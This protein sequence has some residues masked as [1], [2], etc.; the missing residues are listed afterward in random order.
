MVPPIPLGPFELQH[1]IGRG[2]MGDVWQGRHVAQDLPVAIKV[3][4]PVQ[5]GLEAFR[6]EVRA[7]AALDHPGVVA[8]HDMGLL[9]GAVAEASAGRLEAGSPYLVMELCHG[10]TLTPWCGRLAWPA[11]RAVL[12]SL[13]D[14]LAHAHARGVIHRDIKPA[15]VL[16]GSW[17][18][19][20]PGPKLVDFGV[21]WSLRESGALRTAGTRAY[22]APE[23]LHAAEL[24]PWTDLFALGRLALA[25][26]GGA[27]DATAPL[28]EDTP[29][30]LMPW[31]AR[32]LQ[33]DP[34]D[35]YA[36][37]ADAAEAL[38]GLDGA[39]TQN[40]ILEELEPLVAGPTPAADEEQTIDGLLDGATLPIPLADPTIDGLLDGSTLPM[41]LSALFTDR[42]GL[43]AP[44]PPLPDVTP[45][46]RV[47]ATPPGSWRRSEPTP[48]HPPL[49]GTGL[50]LHG[51]RTLPLIGRE[52]LRDR[53]W[54]ALLDVLYTRQARVLL[55]HG[56]AGSGRGR[57]AW[58]LGERATELGAARVLALPPTG[59]GKVALAS[60]LRRF[61]RCERLSPE[62]RVARLRAEPA[63]A[64]PGAL[65]EAIA[66]LSPNPA[67]DTRL[68]G[69]S[70]ARFR[71]PHE[72]V[73]AA[74]S[75]LERLC[76]ER[77]L[78]V[79]VPRVARSPLATRLLTRLAGSDTPLLAVATARDDDLAEPAPS[80]SALLGAPRVAWIPVGPLPAEEHR[81]FVR[82]LLGLEGTLGARI[83]RLTAGN[84]QLAV[85]LLDHLVSRGLLE[86]G[87]KG[88]RL[89]EGASLSLPENLQEA[90][91]DRVEGLLEGHADVDAAALERAAVLGLEVDD[92]EWQAACARDGLEEAG[93]CGL[94][95]ALLSAGLARRWSGATG[96]AFGNPMLREALLRRAEDGGRLVAHHA[97]CAAMLS[98]RGAP[99][100]E[101]QERL[102]RH[103]LAAGQLPEALEPLL[104]AAVAARNVGDLDH[105]ELLLELRQQ[106]EACLP[107]H[108]PRRGEV[109]L[110]RWRIAETRGEV[111]ETTRL[112]AELVERARAEGWEALEAQALLGHVQM[113]REQGRGEESLA[114]ARHGIALAERHGLTTA[115][116]KLHLSMVITLLRLGRR[117][118]AL[119]QLRLAQ[120][121][122][123]PEENPAQIAHVHYLQ[124]HLYRREADHV[125]AR[126]AFTRALAIW[127]AE[128]SRR[129]IGAVCNDL[130]DTE[131]MLGNPA[132]A[133][134]FYQ[135][136]REVYGRIGSGLVAAAEVNLALLRLEAGAWAEALPL[137]ERSVSAFEA[138]GMMA[139]RAAVLVCL[140]PV[141]AAEGQWQRLAD[142]LD[143]AEA[144]LVR[145]GHEQPDVPRMAERAAEMAAAADQEALALRLRRFAVAHWRHLGHEGEAAR[146]ERRGAGP[147]ME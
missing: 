132:A 47:V 112:G 99:T 5:R 66:L 23:Q 88:F 36:C 51:L 78:I 83:E 146:L 85:L 59:D 42:G 34:R 126:E 130:G 123:D 101:L 125:R 117:D 16:L 12:L 57:M 103:R 15:N 46:P 63:L 35:R 114:E 45:A 127:R 138:L 9:P 116:S 93:R 22:M 94:V 64:T 75:L 102:G 39:A 24:G 73:T 50:G 91:S 144:L 27:P 110:E 120:E 124:G 131:R 65:A 70:P 105:A 20:R 107:P 13:L 90:W 79:L 141:R 100:P 3:M 67:E 53:L 77:A 119:E 69:L 44:T 19:L 29:E 1:P 129:F 41:E 38:R 113:L 109:L 136:A 118:E 61:L 142:E 121:G 32:L 18:D 7:M 71:T 68:A 26:V 84:P 8:I 96:W 10:G 111:R 48:R 122:L 89:V 108:D 25:L 56:P 11:A 106:A 28:F 37:A 52:D 80:L 60:A 92:A 72:R 98:A 74:V 58:W 55:L 128:G 115:R 104:A 14:A 134:V 33:V 82:E 143:E 21:A 40:P 17:Q 147:S 2:G 145:V 62:A 139:I 87:P 30:G 95:E 76:G 135:E 81:R 97:A 4:P 140:A 49:L 133:E 86:P 31:V 54:A 43:A 6:A 137:L